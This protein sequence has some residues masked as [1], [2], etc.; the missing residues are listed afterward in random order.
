M[1]YNDFQ[2][3]LISLLSENITYNIVQNLESQ[4]FGASTLEQKIKREW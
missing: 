1:K 3:K 4:N 2:L